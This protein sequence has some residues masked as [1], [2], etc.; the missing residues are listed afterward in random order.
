MSETVTRIKTTITKEDLKR[1]GPVEVFYNRMTLKPFTCSV[2]ERC[3]STITY[4]G[5]SQEDVD[6]YLVRH[7]NNNLGLLRAKTA[8]ARIVEG[9]SVGEDFSI[10]LVD[11]DLHTGSYDEYLISDWN[12]IKL[13]DDRTSQATA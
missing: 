8:T 13:D 12:S 6:Y 1:T 2:I 5:G 10:T 7:E 11:G 9:D 3:T 4:V